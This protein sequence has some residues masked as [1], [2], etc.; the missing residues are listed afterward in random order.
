MQASL[1][2]NNSDEFFLLG[3]RLVTRV[4]QHSHLTF[5]TVLG[6]GESLDGR[7][8]DEVQQEEKSAKHEESVL[9][10]QKPVCA[11]GRKH[12]RFSESGSE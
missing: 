8:C 12:I 7:A 11:I 4:K 9:S 6:P 5:S 2:V 1:V 10:D 3:E